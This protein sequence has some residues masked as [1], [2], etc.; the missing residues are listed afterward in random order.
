[1][2]LMMSEAP[3]PDAVAEV[4]D[5]LGGQAVLTVLL[6]GLLLNEGANRVYLKENFKE[7]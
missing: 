5:R 1:M 7:L 2:Y 3:G 4:L 6:I